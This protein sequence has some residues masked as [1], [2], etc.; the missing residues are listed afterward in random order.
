MLKVS[1]E[2]RIFGA[3]SSG[4]T[5]YLTTLA[6]C[7]QKLK[8][9]YP[10]LDVICRTDDTKELNNLAKDTLE[11]GMK[12]PA[13]QYERKEHHNLKEYDFVIKIPGNKQRQGIELELLTKDFPGEFFHD[14]PRGDKQQEIKIWIEDLF[15]TDGWMIMMT[16]WE[17]GNDELL[18][19]PAFEQLHQK[20]SEKERINSEL[21][22][23]RIAVVMT[24]CERG[25]LW[26]CRLDPDEDL[27]EVRLPETYNF[28]KQKFS[29][30]RLQFFACSA[31]GILGDDLDDPKTFDPRPNCYFSDDGSPE[32][33][34]ATLKDHTKWSPYGLIPPLYWLA[35]GIRLE[36]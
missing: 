17:P 21:E 26:P 2:I 3:R 1:N 36:E 30:E 35:K 13:T 18:Y 31:F 16:D 20:L 24:K 15:T 27:F 6:K 5:T 8:K 10:G 25:E 33:I 23:L 11:I 4:K 22:K 28:L 32:E 29:P 12:V 14:I 19:K 34:E 7:P 9:K